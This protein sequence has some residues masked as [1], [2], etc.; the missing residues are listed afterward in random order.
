ML[1]EEPYQRACAKIRH[2]RKDFDK[3]YRAVEDLREELVTAEAECTAA[4][5]ALAAAEQEKD[6]LVQALA[7][8]KAAKD[9]H[10]S[11]FCRKA[12][13]LNK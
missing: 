12:G 2:A 11:S 3:A 10:Y 13:L 8:S 5:A 1:D 9:G 6:D 7:R 4:A